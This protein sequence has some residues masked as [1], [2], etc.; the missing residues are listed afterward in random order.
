MLF[1]YLLFCKSNLNSKY[2]LMSASAQNLSLGAAVDF[3]VDPNIPQS[4]QQS[5]AQ[6]NDATKAQ[7]NLINATTTGGRRPRRRKSRRS[8]KGGVGGVGAE[9]IPGDP[10]TIVV[11]PLPLGSDTAN[12]Q[13]NNVAAAK[14]FANAVVASSND[15]KVAQAGGK[16]R[17]R[18][19]RLSKKRTRRSRSTRSVKYRK[20]M[21][22]KKSRRTRTR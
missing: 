10:T 20:M 13:A 21:K 9:T 14:L 4:S 16:R 12:A 17:R 11:A 6:I 5:V 7:V 3:Q 1:L 15:G 8:Y 19:R 22:G 2:R 18:T